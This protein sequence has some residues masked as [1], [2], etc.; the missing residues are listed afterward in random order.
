MRLRNLY[1]KENFKPEI[2]PFINNL[3]DNFIP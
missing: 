2:R 3:Q 1:K